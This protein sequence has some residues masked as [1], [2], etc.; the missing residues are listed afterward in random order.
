MPIHD[1]FDQKLHIFGIFHK[2]LFFWFRTTEEDKAPNRAAQNCNVRA[3]FFGYKEAFS[4]I[5]L[6]VITFQQ[7]REEAEK[8][9]PKERWKTSSIQLK[10]KQQNAHTLSVF[11]F[12]VRQL[13]PKWKMNST[14]L[15]ETHDAII[16]SH[17]IVSSCMSQ[18]IDS[19]TLCVF[20]NF[21]WI[22]SI[23]YRINK[24]I[25]SIQSAIEI[26]S[27]SFFNVLAFFRSQ[28]MPDWWYKKRYTCN[29]TFHLKVRTAE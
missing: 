17:A 13:R 18:T 24:L 1:L 26:V 9:T 20:F 16:D 5:C 15:M 12:R 8:K 2:Y 3:E 28:R 22:N 21:R 19:K 25:A 11:V 7:G 29:D 23:S 10:T 4:S 6:A 14:L 27:R